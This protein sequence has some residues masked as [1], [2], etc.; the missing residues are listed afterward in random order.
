MQA[1]PFYS[2]FI[3]MCAATTVGQAAIYVDVHLLVRL[4]SQHIFSA[5]YF[6]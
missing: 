3:G 2:N 1:T 5:A 4:S 6:S